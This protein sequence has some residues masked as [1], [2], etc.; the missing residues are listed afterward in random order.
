MGVPKR[1]RL[2]RAPGPTPLAPRVDAAQARGVPH[3]PQPKQPHHACPNC[4]WYGGREAVHIKQR[5]KAE[6]QNR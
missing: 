6:E 3:C 1:A 5:T 2:T 4:G